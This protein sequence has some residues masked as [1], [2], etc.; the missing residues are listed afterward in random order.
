MDNGT[1][2]NPSLGILG[3]GQLGLYLCQAARKLGIRTLVLEPNPEG[4]A[5]RAA[6]TAIVADLDR[7]DAVQK[8]IDCSDVITFELEAIPDQSLELL[9]SAEQRGEVHV[10]P[11]VETLS[12]FKDKG[13][14]KDWLSREGLPTLPSLPVINGALPRELITGEWSLPV[15]QKAHR[16]GYDGKGVQLLRT[17]GDLENLWNI[18]SYLEPALEPCREIGVV[19]ARDLQGKLLAYPSVSMAFDNRYNAVHSVTS[20][21][22]FDSELAAKATDLALDTVSRLGAPGVYAVE[23]FVVGDTSVTINEISPRVHNSGHLTMEGFGHSQFEQ[24]VRAVMGLPLADI[25]ATRP[26][27][28][29]LNLLFEDGLEPVCPTQPTDLM[30]DGET[31]VSI[32]WYGKS[33]GQPGRKMGH[34]TA[35]GTDYEKVTAAAENTLTMLQRG[36]QTGLKPAHEEKTL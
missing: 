9:H 3:G 8:L 31:P 1:L 15:V 26:V 22:E 32:H 24:H 21:G 6:D 36:Q 19:V 28:V 2:N 10:R 34:L 14:Q 30:L 25:T 33:T 5:M 7:L 11:S 17:S 16:G 20:P 12:L 4:S 29:M 27:A 13:V 35:I 23:L 18:P